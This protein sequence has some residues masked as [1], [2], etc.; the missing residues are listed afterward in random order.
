MDVLHDHDYEQKKHEEYRVYDF[1]EE[2]FYFIYV[3]FIFI[4][5][6]IDIYIVV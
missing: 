3:C 4:E 6:I 1:T 5:V 2:V